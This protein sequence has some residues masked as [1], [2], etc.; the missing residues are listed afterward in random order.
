MKTFLATMSCY[1]FAS[2]II[3]KHVHFIRTRKITYEDCVKFIFW[4][5][6]RNNDTELTEFFKVFKGK[7]Y[8]TISHQAIG[9]QR[10]FIKPELF[11]NIYKKFIDT[12]YKEHKHFS[13]I[14]G[15]IVAACDGSIFDLP[16][17]TLTRR[18]FNIKDHDKF[19]KHRIRARVSGMLD[20][21][22][23]FMLTTKIVEKSTTEVQLA[24]QHLNDLKN[25]LDITKFI[26][27]YDRGY[28]SIEL[29]LYTE[30]LNSK[31]LIRLPKNTFEKQRRKIKSNDKIIEINLTNAIIKHFEN[32]DLKIWRKK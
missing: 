32:E 19:G 9:K 25:R 15:Y 6:G 4:N 12:I 22:S 24:I 16:N 3:D 28:K 13:K 30:K 7:K 11:I 1:F 26:A 2:Y 8:E 20:V 14:K 29:M 21:N 27:V 10:I 17:V 31:F 5:K 23:K 18:E